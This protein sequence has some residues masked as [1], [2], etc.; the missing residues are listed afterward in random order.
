MVVCHVVSL[1]AQHLI[2]NHSGTVA[3]PAGLLKYVLV[4]S[5]FIFVSLST[6]QCCLRA[7]DCLHRL[8]KHTSTCFTSL[9]TLSRIENME[10]LAILDTSHFT[11]WN[12]SI[13][14]NTPPGWRPL[15]TTYPSMPLGIT[16][17]DTIVKV[18]QCDK[19]EA[20]KLWLYLTRSML[21]VSETS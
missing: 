16:Y 19:N 12:N 17:I 11:K 5:S 21:C 20:L 13:T 6:S 4:L 10:S 15:L 2:R 1:K 14:R 7:T 3:L 8:L 18:Q 9:P